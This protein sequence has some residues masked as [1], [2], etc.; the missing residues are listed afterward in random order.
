MIIESAM[1][2]DSPELIPDA[3]RKM[4]PAFNSIP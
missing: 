1:R 4:A 2:I 3:F